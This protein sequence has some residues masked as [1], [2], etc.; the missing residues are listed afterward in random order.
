MSHATASA[1]RL[2]K[3]PVVELEKRL[4]RLPYVPTRGIRQDLGE[5]VARDYSIALDSVNEGYERKHRLS[6]V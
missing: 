2:H 3:D 1:N 6:Y 5:E 4:D